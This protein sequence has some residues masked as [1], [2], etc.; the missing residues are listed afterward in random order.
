MD[1]NGI[2]DARFLALASQQGEA[3]DRDD[4]VRNIAAQRPRILFSASMSLW[5]R[6]WR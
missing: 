3:A 2:G 4:G 5:H 6:V 1:F